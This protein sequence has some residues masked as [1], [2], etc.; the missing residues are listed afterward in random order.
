MYECNHDFTCKKDCSI[1]PCNLPTVEEGLGVA[2]IWLSGQFSGIYPCQQ[3][4][5]YSLLWKDLNIVFLIKWR[6]QFI[7]TALFVER[8]V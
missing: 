1:Q 6:S 3:G 4:P 5:A 7:V 2:V 8:E